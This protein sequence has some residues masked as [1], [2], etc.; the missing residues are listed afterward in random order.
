MRRAA[1][2][3]VAATMVLLLGVRALDA[4]T[5]GTDL[6]NETFSGSAV[7]D[8]NIRVQ[9]ATCL[10]GRPIGSPLPPGAANI[11]D[12]ATQQGGPVPTPG[13][14]PGYLQITD[15]VNNKTGSV[16]YNRPVPSSAGIIATFDQWQYGG[17]GADGIAFTL[18][19]GA[20]TPTVPGAFGG[21]LGYA[22]RTGVDGVLGGYIGLGLDSFGNFYNDNEGRG[23]GCSSNQRPPF[24]TALVPG[25]LV[26]RGPGNA[27]RGYCYRGSTTTLTNPPM[28]NLPGSLRGPTLA[29]A[30]RRV[31]L[32]VS[33]GPAPRVTVTMDFFDGNGPRQILDIAAPPNPPSTYKFGWTASTGSSNDVHLIRNVVV[34]TVNPLAQLTL[35]KQVDVTN[36][37]NPLVL[38]SV[39]P[40][41]FVV[42]NSGLETLTGLAVTDLRVTNVTCPRTSIDPAPADTS[43]VVCTGSYTVTQADVDAGQIV[44]TATASGVDPGGATIQSNPSTVTLNVGSTPRIALNK[45]ILTPPPYSFGQTVTYRYDV[46]NTGSVSVTLAANG[47]ITDDKVSTITCQQPLTLLPQP[48][49]PSSTSCIGTYVIRAQDVDATGFLTNV[50]TARATPTTGGTVTSPPAT[51]T[52]PV[53]VDIAVT[54]SV[55]VATPTLGDVVTFTVNASNAGPANATQV[56]ITDPIQPGVSFVGAVAPPGTTYDP[57]TGVWNIGNLEAGT[58]VQLQLSVSVT[59]VNPYTNVATL[60]NVNEPDIN[61]N[62]NQGQATITPIRDADVGMA[63]SVDNPTP[64]V[65]QT[66]NFTVTATNGGPSPATGVVVNDAL[67]AGL[68]LVPGGASPTQGTYDAGTG[69]WAVGALPVGGSA[70]LTLAVRVDAPG[71]LTNTATKTAQNEPDPNPNND[72]ASSTVT[73]T[74]VADLRITKTNGLTVVLAGNRVTYTIT[75]LNAGPSNVVGAPVA[76]TF[77]AALTGVTWTCTADTGA[78]CGADAGIGTINTTVDIPAGRFVTFSATGTVDP[79][80]LGTLT[81]TATVAPPAGTTD[82]DPGNNSATDTTQ[83]QASAD[84]VLDKQGPL[85]FIIP[86]NPVDFTITVTNVGP[87]TAIDAV[88]TDATPP[89]L[90]FVSNGGACSTP[91]PCALGTLAPGETRTITTRF[92]VPGDYNLPP[93]SDPDPI[94]NTATVSS[95]TPDPAPGNNTGTGSASL[96]APLADLFVTKDDGLTQVVAGTPLFY[97]ITITNRGPSAVPAVPGAAVS[98]VFPAAFQNPTWECTAIGGGSCGADMGTGNI[99]TTVGLP[100]GAMATFT[101]TGTVAPDFVGQLVNT[102]TATNPPGFGDPNTATATDVTDVVAEAD[103]SITKTGPPVVVPGNQVVYTIVV[104]NN[105]PPPPPPVLPGG[106]TAQNVRV[107]DPTPPGLTFVSNT[108][109]CTTPFPCT[110]GS[111]PPGATRTITA[112]FLVPEGYVSPNPIVNRVGVTSTTTDPNPNNNTAEAETPV[113]RLADVAVTKIASPTTVAIGDTVTFTVG[114]RNN[115]PNVATNVTV[116]DLLPP[117]LQ[118]AGAT[119]SQGIYLAS[120]AGEWSVGRLGVGDSAQ[121]TLTAVVTQSGAITNIATKTGANEPDPDTSNDTATATVN[122]DPSA[123][124]GVAKSVD[125]ATPVAGDPVIFTVRVTNH[126]PDPATGIEVVDAL[127]A[128]VTFVAATPLQ[129]T[130]DPGTGLWTVGD[131]APGAFTTLTLQTTASTAAL[132]VNTATKTAQNEPDPNPANDQS[133]V[134][135][136]GAGTADVAVAKAVSTTLDALGEDASFTVTATNLGPEVATNVVLTD[137]LPPGLQLVSAVPSAAFD[138]ATGR[139]TV[140]TLAVSQSQVLV[141]NV[142]PTVAG[143]FVNTATRTSQDQPDPNPANDSGTA[144]LVVG[145]IADLSI[146]KTDNLVLAVAG[147]DITYEIVVAN[148]GPS[149]VTNARVRDLFPPILQGINWTCTPD[150]GSFCAPP[151]PENPNGLS[152]GGG[153]IDVPIALL[154]SGGRVVFA[155]NAR[156]SPAAGGELVN[157]A[158]VEPPQDVTD[159]DPAN[160][161]ATDTTEIDQQANLEI[162]KTGP[163][164]AVAGQTI[165]YIITVVNAGPSTATD[166]VVDD[167]PPAELAFVSNSG[168]CTTAFPCALGTLAPGDQ[169]VITSTYTVLPGSGVAR[170]TINT[171][172]VSSPTPDPNPENDTSSVETTIAASADLGIVK[173]GPAGGTVGQPLVYTLRITNEG[174]DTAVDAVVSDV[175]PAG[176][177]LVSVTPTQ[178]CSGDP[179]ITCALGNVPAGGVVT[180]T[181]TVIPSVEGGLTNTATVTSQTPDPDPADNTSTI[182]T[183]VASTTTT[184]STS[185]TTTSTPGSSTTT[186]I[187]GEIC[188]NCVDDDGD[189]QIDFD[190]ADCCTQIGTLTITKVKATPRTANPDK[191][192]LKVSGTLGGAGFATLNPRQEEVSVTLGDGMLL[193]CCTIPEQKWMKLYRRHYGFWDQKSRICPPLVDVG[194][195]QTAD[196]GGFSIVGRDVDLGQLESSDLRVTLRVGD[197]CATGTAM[198]RRKK[199]GALVFP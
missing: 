109:A 197:S 48:Q 85:G 156:L 171:A 43:T 4:Q 152:A 34:R 92:D 19:D 62:N 13:V 139:W 74:S 89:G 163:A 82:P 72:T 52:L 108:G 120:P 30:R 1:A 135:L 145:L 155:V 115:G 20:V 11:P 16:I 42:T 107:T 173:S 61:P 192:R 33:P 157:T 184:T 71:T 36:L 103:L 151:S 133:S 50:A 153:D 97:T 111:I 94:V 63:K 166:V 169:R 144:T 138:P 122:G 187:P 125:N 170:T 59:S 195:R 158:T 172:T 29:T 137:V 55:N 88:V 45:L 76:D 3:V 2:T 104:V 51:L 102:V 18:I 128:G 10:T 196:G 22:Q 21:S 7:L 123:D 167:P 198:L 160:N 130:Y 28:T 86:G 189:G 134:T 8:P 119:A 177:S 121:L 162:V 101:V 79:A 168:A 15:A 9:G 164:E 114:A 47:T 75:V 5:G 24:P 17:T 57:V 66:V 93:G 67:P 113:N 37:P 95:P 191:A 84:L 6:V 188:G 91:F 39:I 190:D 181:I 87:S 159:P 80:A 27:N 105:L 58:S 142:R 150:P 126:G 154:P 98:D 77:P 147:Q 110:L 175:V 118:F 141:L 199:S 185:S 100:V 174:P 140:G 161:T 96:G 44:N 117:G 148:D 149:P 60:T 25:A 26:L 129:G 132:Q 143:T 78:R 41:Q 83:I 49:F 56:R 40:Y 179:V 54:K 193:A 46:I 14:L 73:A 53:G 64:A 116:T 70:T 106:S 136:N 146:T 194:L 90:T 186:T 12:C 165:A 68:L 65:G 31:S 182:T 32:T 99:A 81:N 23:S 180:V 35:T 176:S 69:V 183:P 124:V 38:G 127:P 131:L 112:T 178:S